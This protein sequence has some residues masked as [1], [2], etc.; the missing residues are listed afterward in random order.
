MFFDQND[1]NPLVFPIPAN[2]RKKKK[3]NVLDRLSPDRPEQGPQGHRNR[4]LGRSK[5]VGGGEGA[6]NRG[7]GWV[8]LG[9]KFFFFF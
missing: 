2:P 7:N 3:K 6:N 5:D 8:M 4:D 1:L 9:C